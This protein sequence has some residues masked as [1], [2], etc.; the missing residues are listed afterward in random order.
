MV[1]ISANRAPP[2][3]DET[4]GSH[5]QLAT[6]RISAENFYI[7]SWYNVVPILGIPFYGTTAQFALYIRKSGSRYNQDCIRRSLMGFSQVAERFR[8]VD[9]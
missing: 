6:T 9:I 3:S 7:Q 8:M 2:R 5:L 1:L 4:K